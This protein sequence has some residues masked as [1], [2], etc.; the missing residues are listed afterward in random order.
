M[1]KIIALLLCLSLFLV[2]CSNDAT[3]LVKKE[4]IPTDYLSDYYSNPQVTDD[5]SLGKA[6]QT[7]SDEK[8]EATLKAINYVDTTHKIGPVQLDIKDMKLIHLKPDYS[9]ID[10]FQV[11]THD[12]EFDFV[13]MFVE[14]ENTSSEN[15]NFT[16]IALLETSTG[17][18]F[19]W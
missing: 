11:L 4:D 8:G 3:E 19:D 15:V 12:E 18:K 1:G 7:V 16:P 14:I 17:E 10:Y 5:R 2:G 13:K 6:G 9:L